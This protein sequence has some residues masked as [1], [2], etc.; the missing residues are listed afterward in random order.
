MAG[1]FKKD[2]MIR[3]HYDLDMFI[4]WSPGYMT[5]K[6]LFYK[7]ENALRTKWNRIEKKNVGWRIPYTKD[8][9]IDVVPTVLDP[10]DSNYS[11][12][13]N[14]YENSKLRTSMERH[15]REIDKY[16]RREVIKLLKLWKYRREVPLKS[17]LLEILTHLSCFNVTRKYISIQLENVLEHIANNMVE[18]TFYDPANPY[19]IITVDLTQRERYE[20]KDKAYNALNRENWGQLF[21]KIRY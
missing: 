16:N 10:R 6:E 12:L 17:F 13:Y 11:Y 15:I 2:T 5:I 7:V 14:C 9:H 8:F 20:I 19:N 3:Q 4:I 21:Q 1:S 18:G